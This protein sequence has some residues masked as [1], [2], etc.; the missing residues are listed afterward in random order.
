MYL[1]SY[2][3]ITF[4]G[5]SRFETRLCLIRFG[6]RKVSINIDTLR[7]HR[8]LQL[9]RCNGDVQHVTLSLT[10]Q[11]STWILQIPGDRELQ[12]L[13]QAPHQACRR[14]P[15]LWRLSYDW[16]AGSLARIDLPSI[17]MCRCQISLMQ[18]PRC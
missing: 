18:T 16:V 8:R 7:H 10:C 15:P 9:Q 2:L 13:H 14:V 11:K 3:S 1:S 17:V 6:A 5:K 12:R 4:V